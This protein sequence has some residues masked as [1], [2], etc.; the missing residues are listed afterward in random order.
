[1]A[2]EQD[3][4]M[5]K[6]VIVGFIAGSLVGAVLALLY[7]PKAGRELRAELKD[8]AGDIVDDAQVYM[9]KARA[10]ATEII[11]DSREKS[12]E[13]VSNARRKADSIMGEAERIL[14]DAR[15]KQ[16]GE[17]PRQSS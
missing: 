15:S 3:D 14:A 6:G 7:A 4:G 12:N 16:S 9:N 10:K 17:P 8:R 11:S 1:M 2:D 5:A 13:L